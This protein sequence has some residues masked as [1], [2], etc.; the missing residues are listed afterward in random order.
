[1]HNKPKSYKMFLGE[2]IMKKYLKWFIILFILALIIV[3]P[4]LSSKN[5]IFKEINFSKFKEV[6][7]NEEFTFVYIGSPSCS[8][9]I[10]MKPYLGELYQD[11]KVDIYYLNSSKIS[12]S[13]I[14]YI[15]ALDDRL[16]SF[17]TPTF[18]FIKGGKIIGIHIGSTTTY[19]EFKNIFVTYYQ[20]SG[21]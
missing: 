2:L 9:C 12:S 11:Y 13:D 16:S 10:E 19:E 6:L 3:I 15:E 14:S 18:L 17:G 20:E 4:I 7:K 8:H 5:S 1:M 21:K